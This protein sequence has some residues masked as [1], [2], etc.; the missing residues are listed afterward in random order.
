MQNTDLFFVKKTSGGGQTADNIEISLTL[1]NNRNNVALS[2]APK[3]AK[4]IGKTDYLI[5]AKLGS[6]LYLMGSDAKDGFKLSKKTD[7]GRRSVTF[8]TQKLG[9]DSNWIGYYQLQWDRERELFYIDV[10]RKEG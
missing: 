8:P 7:C 9:I 5:P 3:V 6:R 2:L 4:M 1:V 10:D